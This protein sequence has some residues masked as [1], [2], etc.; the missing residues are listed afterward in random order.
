VFRNEHGVT[1]LELAIGIM[2]MAFLSLAIAPQISGLLRNFR[3]GGA[4]KVVWGDLHR[5][6]LLA[7]KEGRTVRVDF[8]SNSYDIVRVDTAE[9]V[10]RRMLSIDYPDVTL[11]ITN[12]TISFGSTGTAGGGSKT[13]VLQSPAG[14]KR[15]TILTTG[16]IG[17]FS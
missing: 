16:R 1:L 11:S 4:T 17:N 7:I 9:V 15:F 8:T 6:R 14:T 2:I 5:A 12:N 10:F 3:L 13:V